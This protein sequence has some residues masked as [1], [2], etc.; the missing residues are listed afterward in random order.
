MLR[1]ESSEPTITDP[2]D[3]QY[4]WKPDDPVSLANDLEHAAENLEWAMLSANGADYQRL[5]RVAKRI[6]EIAERGRIVA[7]LD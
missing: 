7:E 4:R 2:P 5:Y 3:D 6:G 1:Y